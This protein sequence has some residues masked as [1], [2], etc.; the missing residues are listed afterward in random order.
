VHSIFRAFA[1]SG[2]ALI[3]ALPAARASAAEIKLM[4]PAPMRTTIT[5]LVEQFEKK[6][7]HK[8]TIVH[9]PSRMIIE[10]ITG[11]EAFD[12]SI[13]TAEATDNLIKQ[14]KIARRADVARSSIG[15]GVKTGTPAPDVSSAESV[16]RALLAVKSFARNEGAESGK[17]MLAV[18]E[19]LGIAEQMKAKTKAMPVNTGY[20]AELVIRGEAEMA[21]Q[22]MPELKAVPGIDASPLPKD[23]Q[24]V[25]VFSAG[26]SRAPADQ[27]AAQEL[28][29]FLTSADAA[30]VLKAKGLDP[31]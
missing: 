15:L 20:V 30:P 31:P 23:L 5:A 22:Q 11:G 17:H 14:G 2:L 19:R 28:V 10:R 7:P 4:C 12:V 24:L 29:A 6:S 13:L 27:K 1:V 18:F 16:K 26:L 9:T 3:A 21:A 8:V 25:I